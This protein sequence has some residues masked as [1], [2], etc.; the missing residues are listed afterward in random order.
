MDAVAHVDPCGVGMHYLK[1]GIGG[2][3]AAGQ[4]F[5]LLPVQP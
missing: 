5:A 2:L 1:S 4:V 3:Q